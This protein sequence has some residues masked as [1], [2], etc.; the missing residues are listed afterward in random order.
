MSW[1]D[2]V[3]Q[4]A[5]ALKQGQKYHNACVIRGQN[6]Y[7]LVLDDVLGESPV[8]RRVSIG[9]VEIPM[10]QIVGTTT[11]GRKSAFAGNFMPLLDSTTEFGNKWINLCESHLTDGI[12]DPIIC[13]EY[14]GQFYITEGNKR[15]SVLKSYECPS[16]RGQ[17]TR[18]VPPLSDDPRVVAYYEFMNFFQLSELYDVWLRQPGQYPKLQAALGLEPDHVWSKE[19]R[20][21]FLYSF[22]RF[23]A[24]F[25]RLN[26][27]KLDVTA[28]EA[29]MVWLELHPFAELDTIEATELD[30]SLAAIWPDIR[31]L[32]QQSPIQI[33]TE[34]TTHEK[35]NWTRLLGFG[36]IAH[37]NVAFIHAF[38]PEKSAWIAAHELGREHLKA[39]MGDEVTTIVYQCSYEDAFETM[40]KA[41]A[42]GAQVIFATTP[43]MI[44]ACRQIAAKYPQVRVLNCSLS[45]PY[46]GVRTYYTRIHEGKFITGAIAGAMAKEGGIGYVANYPIIGTIAGI[47]AFALGVR[48]TNPTARVKLKWSCL[49]GNPVEELLSEGVTVISNRD[50]GATHPHWAWEW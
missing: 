32:T 36:R 47:N 49:K 35:I 5:R 22:R 24:A 42:D 38:A 44:G 4:Y 34:A 12:H 17:V 3:T 2:A 43:P 41:V 20:L 25:N 23:K 21:N 27:E 1:S 9:L 33:S 7:P 37:L 14:M 28:G 18:V 11:K 48:L 15:V 10:E 39:V 50:V 40:E 26:S 16:I 13:Y 8:A 46:A 45:M 29:L 31:L 19:E 6:P 30:K